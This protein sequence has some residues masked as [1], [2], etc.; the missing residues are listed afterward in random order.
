VSQLKSILRCGE[1][2]RLEKLGF[3]TLPAVYL[4]GGSAFH[5]ASER[6]DIALFEGVH[7]SLIDVREIWNVAWLYQFD[8]ALVQEPDTDKWRKGG[9][10]SKALPNREDVVFWRDKGLEMLE[11]YYAYRKASDF[12][13]WELPDETPAIEVPVRAALGDAEVIGYIDRILVSPAGELVVRDIKTGKQPPDSIQL[14]TYAEMVDQT[15]GI[16]PRWGDYYLS[17]DARPTT[18]VELTPYSH[19]YLLAEYNKIDLMRKQGL[20]LVNEGQHCISCGVKAGCRLKGQPETI[21][22]YKDKLPEYKNEE[23]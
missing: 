10:A 2:F 7:E 21:E 5:S 11:A 1:A 17:R 15:F 13:V 20:Y 18:P 6:L 4:A 14:G 23:N 16:R 22:E 3:P 12:S 9:R 8:K 19:E